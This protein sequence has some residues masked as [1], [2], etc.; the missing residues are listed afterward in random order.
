MISSNE[1]TLHADPR[2]LLARL[3]T[4]GLA[5]AAVAVLAV[6]APQPA[7]AYHCDMLF[8]KVVKTDKAYD[9]AVQLYDDVIEKVKSGEFGAGELRGARQNL[10]AQTKR[11]NA[12]IDEFLDHGCDTK[13]RTD[14]EDDQ[15]KQSKKK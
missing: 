14:D 5:A 15:G 9:D 8:E 2:T 4:V 11:A 7:L 6:S 10:A 3:G 12:A 13:A 1:S